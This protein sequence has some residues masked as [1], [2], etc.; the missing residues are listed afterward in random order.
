V[1]SRMRLHH[2]VPVMSPGVVPPAGVHSALGTELYAHLAS[3]CAPPVCLQLEAT[4]GRLFSPSWPVLEG[5]L[6]AALKAALGSSGYWGRFHTV[7]LQ[8]PLNPPHLQ[9]YTTIYR[10][11]HVSNEQSLH[12]PCEPC[13]EPGIQQHSC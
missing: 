3:E 2:D 13:K 10:S 1:K 5:Q 8:D 11:P 6:A 7:C 12:L 9:V 4:A